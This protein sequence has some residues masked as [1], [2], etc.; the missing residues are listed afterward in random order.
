[1]KIIKKPK[2]LPTQFTCPVCGCVYEAVYGEYNLFC[3]GTM[4]NYM[5]TVKQCKCPI[6]KNM[7]YMTDEFEEDKPDGTTTSD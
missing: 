5:G 2:F 3:G 6:C 7:N 4:R 1:M